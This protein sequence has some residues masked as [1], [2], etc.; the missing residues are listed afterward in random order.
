MS[1]RVIVSEVHRCSSY[2]RALTSSNSRD[3]YLG[4]SVE[5]PV[6]SAAAGKAKFEGRWITSSTM[7]NFKSKVDA[8]GQ[9]SFCPLFRLVTFKET[10]VTTGLRGP[11]EVDLGE[12]LPDAVPPWDIGVVANNGR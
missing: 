3:L 10:A 1:N 7:G 9:R 4:V 2:I 5:P 6:A 8:K 12:P 11:R